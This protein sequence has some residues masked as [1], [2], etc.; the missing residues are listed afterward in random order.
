MILSPRQFQVISNTI[1]SHRHRAAGSVLS[2]RQSQAR[3]FLSWRRNRRGRSCIPIPD[4]PIQR[5]S[6]SSQKRQD[7]LMLGMSA[8]NLDYSSESPIAGPA[9]YMPLG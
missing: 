8:A 1:G 9:R 2:E 3:E 7:F 6:N 5:Q 4:V